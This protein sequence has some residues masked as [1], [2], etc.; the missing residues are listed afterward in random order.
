MMLTMPSLPTFFVSVFNIQTIKHKSHEAKLTLELIFSSVPVDYMDDMLFAKQTVDVEDVIGCLEPVYKENGIQFIAEQLKI[1][2][3]RDDGIRLGFLP[4]LLRAKTKE[5]PNF[6]TQFLEFATG[7][8]YFPQNNS[9]FNILVEFN[10]KE[11]KSDDCLMVSHSCANT[12]KF[13]GSAYV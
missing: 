9:T 10:H 7:S 3:K 13:P 8:P 12:I 11:S 4:D 1:L 2:S 6:A 5:N